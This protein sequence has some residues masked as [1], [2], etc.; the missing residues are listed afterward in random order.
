LTTTSKEP[1]WWDL[2]GSD[3]ERDR[4]ELLRAR[5]FTLA[6]VL[7]QETEEA[8][9]LLG[10]FLRRGQVS[11]LGGHGGQGKST[12]ALEM[13]KATVTGGTFLGAVGEGQ[14]AIYVDLEQGIGVAQRAVMKSFYPDHYQEGTPPHEIAAEMNLGEHADRVWWCDWREGA[15]PQGWGEMFE[16][17]EELIDEHQP[18]LLAVDPVYKLMMGSSSS[19]EEVVGALVHHIDQIRS[20]HNLLSVLVPMHPRKP[21]SMGGGGVPDL[22]D[23]YGSSIWGRWAGQVFMIQRTTGN[24]ASL[25]IC[26]DRMGLMNLETWT[27]ELAPGRGYKRAVGDVGEDGPRTAEAKVWDLLQRVAPQALNRKELAELLSLHQKV[28]ERATVKMEKQNELGRYK[29]LM[30]EAG[31]N[32]T[33]FYSYEP[34]ADDKVLQ[35]LKME[36]GAREEVE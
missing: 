8:E 1:P 31:A 2:A 32:R 34:T 9:P 12:M 18:D 6:D 27:L 5:V 29:G 14:C 17:V 7:R 26:K 28:I 11:I 23:L 13:V 33:R 22:H 4:K 24:G 30:A 10:N 15:G 16:V 19:E 25:R 36:L 35:S 21:P 20:R 3:A